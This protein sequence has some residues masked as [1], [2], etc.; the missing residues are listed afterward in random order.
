MVKPNEDT[1]NSVLARAAT[2]W[3][4][5]QELIQSPRTALQRGFGVVIPPA[6]RIQFVERGSHLDALIVLPDFKGKGR[7]DEISDGE[8]EAVNGGADDS[9]GTPPW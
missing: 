4:F 1:L 9:G 5:R 8:L 6:F 2:D 7:E 3:T